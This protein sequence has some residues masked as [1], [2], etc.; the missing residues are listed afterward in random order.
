MTVGT[1]EG[2]LYLYAYGIFPVGM[3]HLGKE[4]TGRVR[5]I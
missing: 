3:V 1:E 4:G 2:N 5:T